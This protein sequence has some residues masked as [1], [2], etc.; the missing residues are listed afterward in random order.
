MVSPFLFISSIVF[1][2]VF[3]N[4][5]RNVFEDVLDNFFLIESVFDGIFG[6]FFY[7]GVIF[8]LCNITKEVRNEV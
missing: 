6:S 3:R 7:Y 8:K 1:S 2:N 4:I 5:F